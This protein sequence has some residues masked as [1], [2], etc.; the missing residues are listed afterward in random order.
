MPDFQRVSQRPQPAGPP[1]GQP[2]PDRSAPRLDPQAASKIIRDGDVEAL[3][4]EAQR[5]APALAN[6]RL[7]SAQMRN[8]FGEVRRI[9]LLASGQ[10]AQWPSVLRQLRLLKPKLAYL[11]GRERDEGRAGRA[12]EAVL[13]PA[14]DQVGGE[15]EHFRRFVEFCEALVA[16]HAREAREGEAQG[17]RGG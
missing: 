3:I 6:E 8:I 2:P 14:I 9:E 12:L 15:P 13:V 7:K 1:R 5:L 10:N 4:Q 11:G 17:R 16:Y